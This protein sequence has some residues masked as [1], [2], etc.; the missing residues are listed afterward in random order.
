MHMKMQVILLSATCLVTFCFSDNSKQNKGAAMDFINAR[1][2]L[3]DGSLSGVMSTDNVVKTDAEWRKLLTPEQYQVTRHQATECAFTGKLFHNSQ[4][5]IY[6][7]VCCGLPLFSS[8]T[9]FESHTGWPSFFSPVAKENIL[10]KTDDSFGM[11]R[12][13]VLCPR[14]GAHMGHVFEDGPAPT[15][16]RYCMNSAAL[17]FIHEDQIKNP[18]GLQKAV[19]GA[20]CF[21]GV[22]ETFRKLPGVEATA[23]GFM[24]G[25][26]KNPSYEQV[27][28]H[29]TGHA[30]VLEIIYNPNKITYDS[31]LSVFWSIHDPTMLNRQGPDVGDN[32]RSVIFYFTPEQEK[33]AKESKSNLEQ[34]HRFKR[35]VVT[36]ISPAK[37]FYRAEEYHQ[38]YDQ[39]TGNTVCGVR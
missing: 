17:N 24:G 5:G 37:E 4:N 13:E 22:E 31:L 33:A 18:N 2:I 29:T 21:W 26:V 20:G 28:T 14:C 34:S 10:E 9:K 15:H 35:P 8:S 3:G 30:E 25:I 39:K 19:F 1:F 16:L 36:E 38:R 32:Y 6:Y 27:C 12:T 11:R 23:V 7:C